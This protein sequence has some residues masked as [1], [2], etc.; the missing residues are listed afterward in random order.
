M[1]TFLTLA[2]TSAMGGEWD[3]RIVLGLLFAQYRQGLSRQLL[4]REDLRMT[5]CSHPRRER[6]G[7]V[8]RDT[9]WV[10]MTAEPLHLGA[11]TVVST[12]PEVEEA[13]IHARLRAPRVIVRRS[14]DLS[15]HANAALDRHVAVHRARGARTRYIEETRQRWRARRAYRIHT[16]ELSSTRSTPL[17]MRRTPRSRTSIML[18]GSRRRSSTQASP[19]NA[20]PRSRDADERAVLTAPIARDLKQTRT[21]SGAG[22]EDVGRRG[23]V[24]YVIRTP[25]KS[26]G[27]C[28]PVHRSPPSRLRAAWMRCRRASD[29]ASGAAVSGSEPAADIVESVLRA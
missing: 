26:Q 7:Y 12:S 20:F 4:A 2:Q 1:L 21:G 9:K 25:R 19:R 13:A 14:R 22:S 6:R 28:T 3:C 27:T 23:R 8:A 18:V 10:R 11:H 17:K 15:G 24:A 29:A 16:T 5:P